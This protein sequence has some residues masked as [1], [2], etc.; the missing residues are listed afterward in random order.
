MPSAG[1]ERNKLLFAGGFLL[2]AASSAILFRAVVARENASH[3][4]ER[5]FVS[6]MIVDSQGH[7][8]SGAVVYAVDVR[9]D[10]L[11][12]FKFDGA[13]PGYD[14]VPAMD[15]F[16]VGKDGRYDGRLSFPDNGFSGLSGQ[17]KVIYFACKKGFH[18]LPLY[19]PVRGV[20]VM[21]RK[22]EPG[23]TFA[24]SMRNGWSLAIRQT[25]CGS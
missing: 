13:S 25:S 17:E 4:S 21:R 10:H 11:P 14:A 18:L 9:M 15:R 2:L 19:L 1:E 3:M 24:P 6:G 23:Y 22:T 20:S 16:P 8:V 5:P 7:P 12:I